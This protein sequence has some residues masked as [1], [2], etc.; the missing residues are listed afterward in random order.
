[1]TMKKALYLGVWV[2]A[3][4]GTTYRPWSSVTTLRRSPS[5]CT[6]SCAPIRSRADSRR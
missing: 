3:R 2:I 4:S 5:S 6:S 1:M